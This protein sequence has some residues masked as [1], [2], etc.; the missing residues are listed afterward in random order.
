MAFARSGCCEMTILA[1]RCLRSV[2]MRSLSTACR[3]ITES[4]ALA[5]WLDAY[6]I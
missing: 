2:M 5:K 6:G 4:E 1:P 3:Q